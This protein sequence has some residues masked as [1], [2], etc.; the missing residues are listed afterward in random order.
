MDTLLDVTRSS[1]SGLKIRTWSVED[2]ATDELRREDWIQTLE[3]M[4]ENTFLM[5]RGLDLLADLPSQTSF[6]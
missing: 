3:G 5:S 6:G 2:T 1:H 4:I